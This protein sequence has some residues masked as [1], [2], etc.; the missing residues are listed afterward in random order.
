MPRDLE[1][2][3]L[4]AIDKDPD[5][6]Y[7]TADAL[8]E[9]LR[10][11]LDDRPILA[12]RVGGAEKFRRWCRRNPLPAGLL[13]GVVLVF[14]AGFAGV[15]WQWRQAESARGQER[16]HRGRAEMARDRARDQEAKALGEKALAPSAGGGRPVGR[17]ADRG[18]PVQQ[19]HRAGPARVSGGQRRRF[20]SDP[21]PLP[22]RP[23]QLGVGLPRRAQPR[24]PVHPDR[25][26]ELGVCRRL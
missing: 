26:H 5:R 22:S 3:V 16:I 17:R 15:S 7:T 20:R 13:A 14:L 6:R 18:R 4:K 1:T 2:I 8:A 10:R 25:T 19:Q 23:S 12:R 11:F 24:R 9:D 21:R